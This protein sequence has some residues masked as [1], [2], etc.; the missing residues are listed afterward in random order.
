MKESDLDSVKSSSSNASEMST[1]ALQ[2]IREQMASSLNKIRDLEEQNKLIP[3]LQKQLMGLR[4]EKR[5]LESLLM[6]HR[7]KSSPF[8][9]QRVSPVHLRSNS[10]GELI[11]PKSTTREIG[12]NCDVVATRDNEMNTTNIF[13]LSRCT[14]TQLSVSNVDSKLYTESEVQKLMESERSEWNRKLTKSVRETACQTAAAEPVKPQTLKINQL[15]QTDTK[16]TTT[17][18]VSAKPQTLSVGSSEHTTND[19]ICDKC[20]VRKRTIACGTDDSEGLP[21]SLKLL[22]NSSRSRSNLSISD[23]MTSSQSSS[24]GTQMGNTLRDA[25]TQSSTVSVSNKFS[26]SDAVIVKSKLMDTFDLIELKHQSSNTV[27]FKEPEPKS[28]RASSTNTIRTSYNDSGTNTIPTATIESGANTEVVPKRDV[29][30]GGDHAETHFTITCDMKYCEPCKEAIRQLAKD[31][32]PSPTI[33]LKSPLE[34][35][36][37]PRPNAS[38]LAQRKVLKRQDTYSVDDKRTEGVEDDKT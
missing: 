14:G 38:P 1:G 4:D 20:R 27:A 25:G 35:S 34:G 13:R 31:V 5:T 6:S 32:S 22:E 8:S 7:A 12:I 9:T 26:Q 23:V 3:I 21:L 28:T 24:I 2:Y 15:S 37:I 11:R 36:R 16:R 17:V 10:F 30:V 18:G 19:V 29:A 33:I